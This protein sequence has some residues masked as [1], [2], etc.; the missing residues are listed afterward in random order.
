MT[1]TDNKI[2]A[3]Y[4]RCSSDEAKKEGYSPQTQKEKTEKAI[5]EYGWQTNKN[6]IY[7]D[8]GSSGGT[9]K[10]PGLQQLIKD[11]QTGKF[12]IVVV[13]RMDRFFRDVR[14]LLNTIEDLRE[15]GIGFK[16]VTEPFDTSTPTGRAMFANAGIF[17]QWMREIGLESRNEGMIKAMKEGKYL[18]GTAPYGY[19]LNRKTQKL[20]INKQE[21]GI[22]K[23]MFK[24]LT[25]EK[26][27]EYK[28]QNRLNELKI[29]T[30]YDNLKR[31]K[32]TL[33][34]CWWN[35]RA[36]GRIL[37]N[38]RYTG[39]YYYRK[40]KKPSRCK[41][42]SNLRPKEDWIKLKMPEEKI[43]S[44]KTF[45]KAQKQL[46]RN[47]ELS[48]RN[49]KLIYALQHKIICGYDGRRY[50][51]ARRLYKSKKTGDQR[52]TKYYFC[53]AIRKDLSAQKCPSSTISDSRILP[54]VWNKIKE[55]LSDPKLVMTKLEEYKQKKTDDKEIKAEIKHLEKKILRERKKKER[56]AELYAEGSVLKKF[57]D[58]K[59]KKCN[60]EI[61]I[62]QKEREKLSQKLM[63]EEAR[64][65]RIESV[66][67]LYKKLKDKL[68]NATYETKREVIQLLIEKIVKTGDR[69]EI[70]LNI[71]FKEKREEIDSAGCEDRR[72][73]D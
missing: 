71:P 19:D 37:R 39:I 33:S 69:L 3:I 49:T 56:Y 55:I 16:S 22:V 73:V 68:E 62:T 30:K 46:K 27:S 14:L 61:E 57:Y 4:I 72:R 20:K 70:E 42:K 24:W 65:E 13:Y 35:K 47:K 11:A 6:L 21:K 50:Q 54:P 18:S 45:N 66:E 53:S 52:E 44:Q 26:L 10:R 51:C 17:A 25:E 28:I 40:Y 67:K 29:P 9:D 23:K 38:E 63:S 41:N 60:E 36:V 5:N 48:K 34:K 59:V 7:S 1:K 8:I 58:Q 31:G 43:I 2:A 15:L 64:K 12:D 32:R